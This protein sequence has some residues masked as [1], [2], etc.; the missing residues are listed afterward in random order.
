[1]AAHRVVVVAQRKHE[2]DLGVLA[3]ALLSWATDTTKRGRRRQEPPEACLQT[4]P[5]SS[6]VG[7]DDEEGRRP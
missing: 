7:E 2:P 1:M 4:E 5:K 6:N 3:G